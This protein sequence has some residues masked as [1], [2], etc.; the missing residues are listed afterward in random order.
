MSIDYQSDSTKLSRFVVALML[1]NTGFAAMVLGGWTY[2]SQFAE[3]P[4]A[5]A[6]WHRVYRSGQPSEIFDYPYVLLWMMPAGAVLIAWV[7][8]K[9]K[10]RGLSLASLTLPILLNAMVMGWFY[11]APYEWR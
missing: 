10:S 1:V 2:M 6:T 4:V 3:E 8:S 9:A 5:W 7:A 11:L